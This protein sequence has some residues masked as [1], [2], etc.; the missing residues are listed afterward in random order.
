MLDR[1]TEAGFSGG[2]TKFAI[3]VG[4][5]KPDIGTVKDIVTLVGVFVGPWIAIKISVGQ[6]TAQKWWE[7][8]ADTYARLLEALS[9]FRWNASQD[10]NSVLGLSNV[11]YTES[12]DH[13]PPLIVLAKVAASG[14]YIISENA[15]KAL[16]HFIATVTDE[17]DPDR[18][19]NSERDIEAADSCLNVVREEA[20]RDV[21]A[22]LGF[23]RFPLGHRAGG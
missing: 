14:N 2:F 5:M 8:K 3:M 11:H 12:S 7:R 13:E 21:K 18:L 4:K 10:Y 19:R 9:L 22:H 1:A 20:N 16:H 6:Y 17:P 15:V 23:F